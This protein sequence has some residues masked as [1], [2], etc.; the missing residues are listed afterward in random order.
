VELR[1]VE[2]RNFTTT[3]AGRIPAGIRVEGSGVGL[4]ILDCKVHRI[5]Q[6]ST[7]ED[8]NGFGI[9]AYGRETDPIDGLRIEGCEVWDLR[10]GQSESVTLNG[11]VVN[12]VVRGNRVHDCN[13]I[14]IDFIGY[15]GTAPADVDRARDGLCA[16]NEVWGV[17]SSHNP[18]YG[19]DFASGGGE[20]SAPGI[21][22]D[23]GTRITIERNQVHDCNIGVELA[24]EAKDGSTDFVVLRNNLLR[25]NHV[26]GLMMGGYDSKRGST[27]N[28]V[29]SNN[30]FHRNDTLQTWTGQ[31]GLQ[32]HVENNRFRNNV[33]VADPTTKQAIVHY[34]EGGTAAQRA[35][36][37]GNTFDFNVY[38]C[39]GNPGDLEFGLNPDG[40]GA[41]QGNRTYSGLTAWQAAVGGDA[42]STFHDP[43]FAGGF[44]GATADAEAFKLAAAS[45]CR[46]RGDPVFAPADDESEFF[47]SSRIANGRVDAGFHEFMTPWQAW[48]DRHFRRPDGGPGAEANDDPDGDGAP[49]L[50]EYSQGMDPKKPDAENGPSG[51]PSGDVFQYRYR[52]DAPDTEVEVQESTTFAPDSWV[53]TAVPEHPENG[54]LFR[55]DFPMNTPRHF[56]R[57]NVTLIAP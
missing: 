23:G 48:R 31:I 30:V 51:A 4:A 45:Y 6:S 18:G 25:H 21:Y 29:V 27:R 54:G 56:V 35:F 42:H 47:G 44:P 53:P 41:D 28:C 24:S 55:R 1:G 37:A 50:L 38:F 5:W 16:E 52:K 43:G 15:E 14:G 17:D 20:T 32:F 40:T 11:N 19:G 39:D 12:F 3:D 22:V 13:N 33:V 57:L 2:I 7:E 46:D 10:T 9:V 36:G 26:A 49:N 8:A 34:V